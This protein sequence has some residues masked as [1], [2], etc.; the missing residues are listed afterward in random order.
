MQVL[1][2]IVSHRPFDHPL[3]GSFERTQFFRHQ[4]ALV[5]R[6]ISCLFLCMRCIRRSQQQAEF[7]LNVLQLCFIVLCS[8][9]STETQTLAKQL[10]SCF[11]YVQLQVQLWC[12][13]MCMSNI[14]ILPD[15]ILIRIVS[16]R[17]ESEFVRGTLSHEFKERPAN[18]NSTPCAGCVYK[19]VGGRNKHWLRPVEAIKNSKNVW[20]F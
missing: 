19:T 11:K 13:S 7:S 20:W 5:L 15:P 18:N 6:S 12:G 2:V 10:R 1:F 17:S 9:C 16:S 4:N 14:Q 8:V 3:F